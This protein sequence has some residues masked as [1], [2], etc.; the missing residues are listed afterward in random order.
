MSETEKLFSDS[1]SVYPFGCAP[2]DISYGGGIPEG[3]IIELFGFESEGKSTLTLEMVR[4]YINFMIKSGKTDELYEVLW[5]ESESAFGTARAIYMG[6]PIDNKKV[7]HIKECKT[8]EMTELTMFEYIVRCKVQ[9]KKLIVVWD[10][11]A[12]AA[13]NDDLAAAIDPKKKFASGMM[14]KPRLIRSLLTKVT[15]LC[16]ET[17]TTLILVNQ[18]AGSKDPREIPDTPGGGAP[19]FFASIRTYINKKGANVSTLPNG[20]IIED[21]IICELFHVKNKLTIPRQKVLIT[22]H[23]EKG[24]DV[25]ATTLDYLQ[26]YKLSGIAGSWKFVEYPE[27][28]AKKDED[29]KPIV[30]PTVKLSFQSPAKVQETIEFKH[31]HLK[32][33]LDYLVYRNATTMS[34]LLKVNI[35]QKVWKYEEMF[36]GEKRTTLTI[37][38]QEVADFMYKELKAQDN[39]ADLKD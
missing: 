19:K 17:G 24:L 3:K 32:D 15:N 31:P 11:L 36:F 12:S 1:K 39:P 28:L 9:N 6:I 38:E 4:A 10:T 26:L 27:A 37:K 25:M 22:L 14:L 20:Q 29:G 5:I 2:L 7:F 21:S 16:G 13:T 34:P 18:A 8:V 30:A 23:N 35:I 33:W